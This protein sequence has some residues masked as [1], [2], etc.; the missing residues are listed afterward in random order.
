MLIS[1]RRLREA[2][3]VGMNE[4]NI[5]LIAE[6]NPRH[7]YPLVDDKLRTKLL[8]AKHG[9][10]TP[11]LLVALRQQHDLQNL[12]AHLEPHDGF[13]IKPSKGSGGKGILVIAARREEYFIKANGQ[14]L[15]I[16]E[17]RRHV[18]NI[19]SGLF[20][21][22][23]T[24]DAAIVEQLIV[25]DA[26]FRDLSVEGVPDIRVIVYRGFPL[27]A[28][29]RLSTRESDGKANLHQGA[30]GLGLTISDGRPVNA[31]QHNVCVQEHPDSGAD[32]MSVRIENWINLLEIAARSADVTGLGYLGADIVVDR[33]HGPLLLEL[34]AR[35]GLAIQ[36]ANKI[37]LAPRVR[38]IDDLSPRRFRESPEARV[39]RAVSMFE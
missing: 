31:I 12:S 24:P 29:M 33:H 10:A 19:L 5:N 28:M 35:P 2:G 13:A 23:G 27:M 32:L 15:A 6:R 26:A 11:K 38:A 18:S 17:I 34:N 1:P 8:A 30:I 3:V 21:L 16:D 37:G 7:L 14:E 39:A 36:L 20:S 4:R 22:G 9:L 25:P